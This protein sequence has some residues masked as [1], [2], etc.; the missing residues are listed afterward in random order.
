MYLNDFATYEKAHEYFSKLDNHIMILMDSAEHNR[1][2]YG[3]DTI[4][5]EFWDLGMMN[6]SLLWWIVLRIEKARSGNDPDRDVSG[7]GT[8]RFRPISAALDSPGGTGRK[9]G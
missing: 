7:R 5:S 1:P 3:Q 2:S 6:N 4:M 9:T 8:T